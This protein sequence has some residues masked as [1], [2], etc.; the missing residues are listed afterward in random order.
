MS[1]C[2]NECAAHGV[3]TCL[4]HGAAYAIEHSN[5]VITQVQLWRERNAI[6]S[7][8]K[9]FIT[10]GTTNRVCYR[11]LNYLLNYTMH[12]S[13]T[14]VYTSHIYSHRSDYQNSNEDDKLFQVPR[15]RRV[16]SSPVVLHLKPIV[17]FPEKMICY[18]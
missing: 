15:S 10:D 1:P 6:G 9:A 12:R 11:K 3:S 17:P 14:D 13:T 18:T 5:K 7:L 8:K 16:R 2:P 4:L